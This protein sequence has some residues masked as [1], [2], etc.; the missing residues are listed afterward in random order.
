M[1]INQLFTQCL[2]LTISCP[3]NCMT[4][5]YSFDPISFDG[6]I[7]QLDFDFKNGN[8]GSSFILEIFDC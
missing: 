6:C 8:F 7:N 2:F 5:S 4:K 3:G 1:S